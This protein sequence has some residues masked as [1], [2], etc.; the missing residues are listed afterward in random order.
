M[1]LESSAER[2][3]QRAQELEDEIRRRREE[4]VELGAERAE[5]LT[6]LAVSEA[7][8]KDARE[9]SKEATCRYREARTQAEEQNER[10]LGALH[11][12]TEARW[13]ATTGWCR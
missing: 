4:L 8:A 10:V 2:E 1:E 9:S 7:Q 3:S 12:R 13:D 5:L 6:E 11:S